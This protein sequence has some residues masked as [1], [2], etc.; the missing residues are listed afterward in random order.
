M[1]GK[2]VLTEK[3]RPGPKGRDQWMGVLSVT[4]G[5]VACAAI[6]VSTNPSSTL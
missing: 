2:S 4:E 6:F 5:M 1:Y 3:R